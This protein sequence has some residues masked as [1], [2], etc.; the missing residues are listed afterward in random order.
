MQFAEAYTSCQS[1]VAIRGI[2]KGLVWFSQGEKK[3]EPNSGT[4][5]NNWN[6]MSLSLA[7]MLDVSIHF[8][9]SNYFTAHF[10][11][12]KLYI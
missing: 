3:K 11:E 12:S 5:G 6:G 2:I 10:M 1:Q 7:D 4:G 9:N 8:E